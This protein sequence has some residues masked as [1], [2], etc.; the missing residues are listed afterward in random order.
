MI[1]SVWDIFPS[2]KAGIQ[3]RAQLDSGFRQNDNA[4]QALGDR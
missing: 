1:N 2:L 3:I 4:C